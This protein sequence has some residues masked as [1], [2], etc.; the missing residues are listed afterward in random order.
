MSFY[1]LWIDHDHA[2]LFNFAPEGEV[3]TDLKNQ[4]HQNHHTGHFQNE[5]LEQQKKFYAEVGSH[6]SSNGKL[7]VLGPSQAKAEFKKFLEEHD[8]RNLAQTI[9][10]VET[11]DQMSE[12]Q[13][14]DFA[15][16]FFHRYNLYN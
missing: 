14:R 2:K 3:V 9:I 13:I 5:K 10:A 8:K 16:N 6:L 15:K 1:A 7:L 11:L 4:H 12:G